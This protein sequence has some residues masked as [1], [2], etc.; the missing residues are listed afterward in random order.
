LFVV[1]EP[2]HT[3]TFEEAMVRLNLTEQ[4]IKEQGERYFNFAVL[5]IT[6]SILSIV[7]AFYLLFAERTFAGFL[8]GLAVTMLFGGQA[9]RYHFWMFQI[10]SRRLGCTLEEWKQSLFKSSPGP[11][12]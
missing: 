2:T 10:R 5:F 11:D 6:L 12:A 3:E 1:S 7:F 4:D 8:L 9:V